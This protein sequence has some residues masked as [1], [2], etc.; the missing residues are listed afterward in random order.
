M[1]KLKTE[2]ELLEF[3][4]NQLTGIYI[5]LCF[6]MLAVFYIVYKKITE[7]K[8]QEEQSPFRILNKIKRDMSCSG[9]KSVKKGRYNKAN[10]LKQPTGY[11]VD[12]KGNVKPKYN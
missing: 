10:N 5:I 1:E 2:T 6:T 11:T 9:G 7:W 4:S 12:K 8:E 3:I